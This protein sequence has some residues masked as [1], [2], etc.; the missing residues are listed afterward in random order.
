M[1]STL[2][3]SEGNGLHYKAEKLLHRKHHYY[4]CCPIQIKW[5]GCSQFIAVLEH[6]W[7][8]F[9]PALVVMH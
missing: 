8:G 1:G 9:L 3:V 4:D 5:H 7:H 2:V 6:V